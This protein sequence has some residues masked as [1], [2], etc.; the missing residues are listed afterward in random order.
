MDRFYFGF[1]T[2]IEPKGVPK[3]SWFRLTKKLIIM[4]NSGIMVNF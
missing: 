1:L 2:S 3:V 4:S